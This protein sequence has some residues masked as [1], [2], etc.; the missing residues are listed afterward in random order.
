MGGARRGADADS[1]VQAGGGCP[2]AEPS[3]VSISSNRQVYRSGEH[4]RRGELPVQGSVT[5]V[6][7]AVGRSSMRRLIRRTVPLLACLLLTPVLAH[8]QASITGVVVDASGAVLPGVAVE[9]SSP[10][11]IEQSRNV[12]TDVTGRY[13]VIQLRPG[14]YSVA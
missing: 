9:V 1:S 3:V 12:V 14:T 8:A 5:S 13:R 6:L 10:A 11:L 7:T 4:E 2:E